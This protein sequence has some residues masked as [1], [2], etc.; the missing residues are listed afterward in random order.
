MPE[1]S[2]KPKIKLS[3]LTDMYD[4]EDDGKEEGEHV[5]SANDSNADVETKEEYME[6]EIEEEF[7]NA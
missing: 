7:N 1:Q 4:I 5:N 3:E 2:D 6:R